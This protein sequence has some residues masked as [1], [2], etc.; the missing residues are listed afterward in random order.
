LRLAFAQYDLREGRIQIL[1]LAGGEAHQVYVKGR[2]RLMSLLWAADGKGL[3]VGVGG[4]SVSNPTLLY[5]DLE[6]RA[7]V[8]WQQTTAILWGTWGVPSPDGRHLALVGYG[9]DN[10]VWMLENF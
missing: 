2:S 3:L 7:E 5:V 6:G 10:N 1:P 8:L 4:Y 9:A